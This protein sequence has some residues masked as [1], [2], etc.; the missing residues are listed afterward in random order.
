MADGGGIPLGYAPM[1]R[2]MLAAIASRLRERP[3]LRRI[4]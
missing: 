4:G 1:R 3:Q 2:D